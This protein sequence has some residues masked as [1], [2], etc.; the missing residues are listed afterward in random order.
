M[1]CREPSVNPAHPSGHYA[2][3]L[4]NNK[5]T[6]KNLTIETRPFETGTAGLLVYDLVA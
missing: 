6:A 4:A 5:A 2:D 3:L 1:P